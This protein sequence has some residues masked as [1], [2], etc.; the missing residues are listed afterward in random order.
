MGRFD[1]LFEATIG[2]FCGLCCSKKS[3]CEPCLTATLKANGIPDTD[4]N[5]TRIRGKEKHNRSSIEPWTF[6]E[7]AKELGKIRAEQEEINGFD[8]RRH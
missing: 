4:Q 5:K 6:S 3:A 7:M 1:A 2:S 8:S